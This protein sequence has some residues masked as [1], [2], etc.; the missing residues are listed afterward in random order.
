M[1]KIGNQGDGGGRPRKELTG[2]QVIQVEALASVLSQDQLADYLGMARNTFA[3]IM[4]RDSEVSERYK[5]GRAKAVGSVAKSLI[6]Q[7]QDGN[8]SAAI[9]YLKTQAGWRER[10]EQVDTVKPVEVIIKRASKDG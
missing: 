5:R 7:A 8:I 1:A 9:F 10:D 3:E 6:Q 4:K 2:E